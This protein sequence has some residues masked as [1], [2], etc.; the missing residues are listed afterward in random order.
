MV[1]FNDT[2]ISGD[3][4]GSLTVCSTNFSMCLENGTTCPCTTTTSSPMT[5]STM[6][7]SEGMGSTQEE[8][9]CLIAGTPRDG[10]ACQLHSSHTT[11]TLTQHT[12]QPSSTC[13][14]PEST[15]TINST[16]ADIV[17]S[18]TTSIRYTVNSSTGMGSDN[19]DGSS[20]SGH[21][22]YYSFTGL[23]LG[24]SLAF[25]IICTCT[26]VRLSRNR[27]KGRLW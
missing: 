22:V 6:G 18:I 12:P 10:T 24:V 16:A 2:C 17:T 14:P 23:A 1:F 20:F 7:E 25:N 9:T 5:R 3:T 8:G 19:G 15:T 4:L 26:T 27:R 13:I 11:T 21:I